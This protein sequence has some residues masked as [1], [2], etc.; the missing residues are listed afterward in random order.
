MKK[1]RIVLVWILLA[2][3]SS[4]TLFPAADAPAYDLP[5][6]NLGFTS[7]LDGGPPA[8]PGVYF[9]QYLQYWTADKL[10][11]ANGDA[12]LPPVA[13]ED[14]EAWISL[15]QLLYQSDK[16]IL[17]GGKWGVN[18]M[19]P[20]VALDMSY[21]TDLGFP[22]DNGT[23]VGDLLIGPFLQWDPVMG[24]NGPIFMH[25]VE[26]QMIF[27]TGKYDENKELNQGS[28]FFSFNPYWA[29]TLFITPQLTASTRIHYLWNAKNDD[30]N[31]QFAGADDTQAGQAMHANFA[32]AYEVLAKRLRIGINGYYLKQIT[33]MQ[34]DGNDVGDTKEQVLGIGPGLVYHVSQDSHVFFNTYFETMAE[35]R[36]EGKR[37]NLRWVYHF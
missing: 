5:S 14:L 24:S 18:V 32:M 30:P 10:T 16:A 13:D 15:T 26:F 11:N 36:P 28:N 7:F 27:P 8:G 19:L 29:G 34:V 1:S 22:Q 35:N 9:S 31:R 17:A 25:R 2:F 23:G 20:I 21:G 37:C 6:V 4:L 12:L 3:T 33:D